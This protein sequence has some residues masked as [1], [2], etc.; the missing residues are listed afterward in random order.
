MPPQKPSARSLASLL[1]AQALVTFI[2]SAAN[3]ALIALVQ[4]RD[5][6]PDPDKDGIKALLG[7]LLV[8]PLV[9]FAPLAGWV[10]DRFSK[11]AV[12]S[13]AMAVQCL[14]LALLALVL[15]R[16][17][18]WAAIGCVFIMSLQTAVFAPAKRA[19]LIELVAPER[20]SR[21]VGLME[22]LSVTAILLGGFGGARLF[23]YWTA[24]ATDPWHGALLRPASSG[25]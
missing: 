13:V 14:T 22:M 19:I 6:L 16:H 18:M 11:S 5:V 9:L 10:N 23:D 25:S 20:L 24:M 1:V 15:Q 8:A 3:L 2:C 17:L 12:L 4:F 21:A 7:I